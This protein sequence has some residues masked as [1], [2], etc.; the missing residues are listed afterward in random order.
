MS[1]KS[2]A[3]L[4]AH[5]TLDPGDGAVVDVDEFLP[6]RALLGRAVRKARLLRQ[7]GVGRGTH[8]ALAAGSWTA[9]AVDYLACAWL[10]AVAVLSDDERLLATVGSPVVRLGQGDEPPHR[11]R[12]GP[13]PRPGPDDPLD[14]IFSSG[15]TG[16]PKPTVSRHGD[17]DFRPW[18]PAGRPADRVVHCGVPFGTS[19]GVHG[20][21]LRHLSAGVVSVAARSVAEVPELADRHGCREIVLTPYSLRKLLDRGDHPFARIKTVKVLAGPVH[22]GLASAAVEAFPNARIFSIYGATELGPA[23][24]TR[25]VDLGE[26]TALGSPSPGTAARVVDAGRRVCAPGEVG[27]IEVSHRANGVSAPAPDWIGTGD[28]GYVDE[29]GCV[30][31]IGRA[32]EI[33]MLPSGRTTP[34]DVEERLLEVPSVRDCGVVAIDSTGEW[35]RLGACIVVEHPAK[36][37]EVRAALASFDPAIAKIAFVSSIP[38]TALGKPIRSRM[39]HMLTAAGAQG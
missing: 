3:Q 5:R 38:R 1:E 24:F 20:I 37:A 6:L 29:L 34:G 39:W 30:F 22:G 25:L 33:L 36:T 21:L 14:V 2:I 32:K 9:T 16:V 4:M 10:G 17:W 7:A 28:L 12:P 15:T 19:T 31:L 13:G 26:S 23:I 8:V 27:E 18:R 11:I 35:D